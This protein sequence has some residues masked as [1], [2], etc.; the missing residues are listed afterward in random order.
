MSLIGHCV[1]LFIIYEVSVG[2]EGELD[3]YTK[4]KRRK[5]HYRG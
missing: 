2:I 4:T 5:P 3:G 1:I